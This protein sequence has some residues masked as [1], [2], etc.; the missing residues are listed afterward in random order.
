VSAPRRVHV[1]AI[2]CASNASSSTYSPSRHTFLATVEGQASVVKGDS[3]L[4]L[5]DANSYWWLVRVLKTEDVGYIP[6]ENVETPYE[7]LARLNKHRNIDIAAPTKEESAIGESREREAQAAAPSN[8][9]KNFIG[10]KTR[11]N[12]S[13]PPDEVEVEEREGRRVFFSSP[14][15]V[16]HPG[17]TW[18][19]DEEDDDDDDDHHPDDME[20]EHEEIDQSLEDDGYDVEPDDGVEWAQDAVEAARGGGDMEHV[21]PDWSTD[22]SVTL[23][24]RDTHIVTPDNA[25]IA[26][27]APSDGSNDKALAAG[28][29]A[30]GVAGVAGVAA[31]V[32]AHPPAPT[33]SPS[34]ATP[35]G[36]LARTNPTPPPHRA[37][38]LSPEL[39]AS[40]EYNMRDVAITPP[41]SGG[42]RSTEVHT[43]STPTH[44]VGVQEQA[45]TPSPKAD[46]S[47]YPS[48]TITPAVMA[49]APIVAPII[50]PAAAAAAAPA[51]VPAA[52]STGPAA[53]P[54][55]PTT[56]TAAARTSPGAPVRSLS[57]ST[58]A[59]PRRLQ[60][61]QEAFNITLLSSL[62]RARA[63]EDRRTRRPVKSAEMD[64]VQQ[65]Y[66][67][68]KLALDS[69][70]PDVRAGYVHLQ[71]KMDS[72]D[73]EIDSLLGSLVVAH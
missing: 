54:T 48:T 44:I 23:E 46:A 52:I 69:L 53:A 33:G 3:L 30:A 2:T 63:D 67:G 7:R 32:A 41:P 58:A 15:F 6:A 26:T 61:N 43:P 18:S 56:P 16:D 38:V 28:I 19:S 66:Y 62:V 14:T 31:V 21:A 35:S 49:G 51:P 68:E 50:T 12:S 8:K 22:H 47:R 24:S 39:E 42:T 11:N 34:P 71:A 55:S 9:L 64:A 20:L 29:G 70:H 60:W 1:Y 72:F 4:L 65:T 57:T 17:V 73:R 40:P 5:D 45:P 10:W 36:A 59:P 37:G 27:V 13:A 25:P